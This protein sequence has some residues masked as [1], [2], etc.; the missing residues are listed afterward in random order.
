M[1][2]PL[3]FTHF[4]LF[5]TSY[6]ADSISSPFTNSQSVKISRADEK[7]D[8]SHRSCSLGDEENYV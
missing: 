7:C 6:G 8:V 2:Y 1:F 5:F 3:N 4:V